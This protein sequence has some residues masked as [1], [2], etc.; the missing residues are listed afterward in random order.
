M[1]TIRATCS[2]CGDVE[3]T[4]SDVRVR[5]CM[6]DNSGSYLFRCPTCRMAVVKPAEPRIV[7]LLVASGVELSTCAA[8]VPG[9]DWY[10]AIGVRSDEFDRELRAPLAKLLA[11]GFASVLLG[12]AGALLVANVVRQEVKRL[13]SVARHGA[14]PAGG[15]P[16]REVAEATE[17]VLSARDREDEL[18]R[19]LAH[20]RH[21]SLTGLPGRE[22]FRE[23]VARDVGAGDPQRDRVALLF[24][25]LDGFK[26]VNDRL[27]HACGDRI[28][29]PV[30]ETLRGVVR[31]SDVP[32][33]VG[34]DEF[35]LYLRGAAHELTAI[36]ESVAQ[37]LVERIGALDQGL[38]CSVGIAL[39]ECRPEVVE[40]LL[41]EADRLMMQAKAEGKGRYVLRPGR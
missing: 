18:A 7:D 27:G 23:L 13:A 20:A 25:D 19:R 26:A 1:P 30:A 10:V 36:A 21:D 2:D 22:L 5:V 34:G 40:S 16:I 24:I 28:L 17:G 41:G 8:R 35:V 4:T 3:L 11:G 29:R 38:G 12:L 37:R 33:R 31:D 6:E 14:S 9:S 39:G 32:G 15:S